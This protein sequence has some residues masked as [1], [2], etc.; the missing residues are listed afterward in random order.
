VLSNA[1]HAC[2]DGT[3]N[4]EGDDASGS[5]TE[6]DPIKCAANQHVLS[7]ACHA[8]PAGKTNDA[9]NDASG[10]D[11]TCQVQQQKVVSDE[12]LDEVNEKVMQAVQSVF[13]GYKKR[14]GYPDDEVLN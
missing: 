13:D 9:G 7:N 14:L 10:A 6:C 11:T 8:C 4:V 5:D 3:T 2:P 1:C 12:Y